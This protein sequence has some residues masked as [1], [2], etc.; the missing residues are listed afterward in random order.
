MWT[1][2]RLSEGIAPEIAFKEGRAAGMNAGMEEK[3]EKSG[4]METRIAVND[5]L[6]GLLFTNRYNTLV[7]LQ[8]KG[9][10]KKENNLFHS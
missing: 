3:S 9:K 7:I 10:A 8:N 4:A 6:G 5:R 1:A 2:Y